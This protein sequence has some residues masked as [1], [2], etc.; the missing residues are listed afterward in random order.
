MVQFPA[1]FCGALLLPQPD[2]VTVTNKNNAT[3]VSLVV[4]FFFLTKIPI[5]VAVANA[6]I[7]KIS[8]IQFFTDFSFCF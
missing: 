6:A 4:F 8:I 1:S 5:P 2:I 7:I 3:I